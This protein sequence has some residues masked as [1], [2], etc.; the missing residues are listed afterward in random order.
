K[1]VLFTSYNC[2]KININRSPLLSGVFASTVCICLIIWLLKIVPY[3]IMDEN[4]ANLIFTI[5]AS[6]VIFFFIKSMTLDP[7]YIPRETD[8]KAISD[9]IYELIKLRKF[10]S[11]HYCIYTNIRK[12]LRSKYSKDKKANIARFDH[13]CPWVNNNI[14]VRN[15]KVFI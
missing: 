6:G 14:G 4:I 9:T 10:D 1:K 2:G 12:P 13:Y 5:G 15:H 7:G 3:T 8:D 11:H